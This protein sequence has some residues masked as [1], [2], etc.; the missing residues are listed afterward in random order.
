MTI[1][2][3]NLLKEVKKMEKFVATLKNVWG[4]VVEFFKNLWTKIVEI[5][6]KAWTATVNFFKTLV[7]KVKALLKK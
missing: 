2:Q 5:S 4:K 7:A 3:Y 1:F 6:K